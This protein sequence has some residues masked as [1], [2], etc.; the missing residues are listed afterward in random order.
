[1]ISTYARLEIIGSDRSIVSCLCV[2]TSAFFLEGGAGAWNA[3][4]LWRGMSLPEKTIAFLLFAM[5]ICAFVLI[6][7]R[8]VIFRAARK[9]SQLFAK[10]AHK[11]FRKAEIDEFLKITERYPRSYTARL[12]SCGLSAFFEVDSAGKQERLEFAMKELEKTSERLSAEMNRSLRNIALIAS[13]APF[14]GLLGTVVGMVESFK[15]IGIDPNNAVSLARGIAPSLATTAFALT[16][17]IPCF[18]AYRYL[19]HIAENFQVGLNELTSELVGYFQNYLMSVYAL[20][21]ALAE[22]AAHYERTEEVW[23]RTR[24]KI[25]SSDLDM[26][27]FGADIRTEKSATD[28]P[29]SAFALLYCQEPVFAGRVFEVAVGLVKERDPRVAGD[30]ELKRPTSSVGPYTLSVQVVA[31]GF[32]LESGETWRNDLRVTA[33]QPYPQFTIHLIPEAQ[34]DKQIWSRTIQAI[35][36][37]DGQTIGVAIRSIAVAR[38]PDVAEQPK[39][40]PEDPGTTIAIPSNVVGPDLEVRILFGKDP[41]RLLFSLMTPFKSVPLPDQ[42]LVVTISTGGDGPEKFARALVDS[43][44]AREGKA[45]LYNHLLGR[46]RELADKLPTEFWD[47]LRRVACEAGNRVLTVLILSQEPY[48]PWELAVMEPPLD[49][50]VPPFLGAQVTVGRWVLK[51]NRPKLPPPN[52]QSVKDIAVISGIYDTTP[53]WRRLV[54]AEKEA[55]E[56]KARWGAAAV[57]ALTGEVLECIAGEPSADVLHFAIHGIYDPNSTQDGLMM[58]DGEALDP[59]TIKGTDLKSQAFVFLNACQVGAGSAVLGDYSGIASAFLDAGASGVIA[60][61]WS[62]KDTIAKEIALRFYDEVFAGLPPAE[63]LRRERRTF[64]RPGGD[65]SATPL[66]YQ[67]FGHPAMKLKHLSNGRG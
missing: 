57:N 61:L 44:N 32:V 43:V 46:G 6:T 49:P 20:P 24:R 8:V 5:L 15:A 25:D 40:H 35:Y 47:A 54:E 23:H 16:I 29:R 33:E 59:T 52:E 60:P 50:E 7:E 65:T 48:I 28:P 19:Q 3:H 66:A 55:D 9:Q 36:S 1:M 12:A 58:V 13:I 17:S 51:R 4:K 42:P 2:W 53:G 31:D 64:K 10:E 67:F 26:G 22:S 56:M 30:V 27:V 45:G 34:D 62:I 11:A 41:G 18:F 14:V 37:I 38:S 39:P 63:F 21:P